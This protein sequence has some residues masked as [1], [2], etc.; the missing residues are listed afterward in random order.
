MPGKNRPVT[1]NDV[2]GLSMLVVG[3]IAFA[4]ALV[5]YSLAVKDPTIAKPLVLAFLVFSTIWAVVGG[6]LSFL[7]S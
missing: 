4:I 6:F 2:L 1:S 3:L 5:V 7:L